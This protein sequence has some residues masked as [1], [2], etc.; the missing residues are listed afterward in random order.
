[1][2]LAII[3]ANS[4]EIEPENNKTQLESAEV[5][6]LPTKNNGGR[7]LFSVNISVHLI[8]KPQNLFYNIFNQI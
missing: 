2:S 8:F 1:M 6:S 4:A 3:Y 7:Y 5:S